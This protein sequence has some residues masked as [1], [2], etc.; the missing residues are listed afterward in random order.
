MFRDGLKRVITEDEGLELVGE[1]GDGNEAVDLICKLKPDVAVMDI[2]LPGINGIEATRRIKKCC[3]DINILC[4]TM[5]DTAEYISQILQVGA[6]GYIIKKAAA[7]E[8][9]QAI[10]VVRDGNSYL[11]PSSAKNLI[12]AYLSGVKSHEAGPNELT[13]REREILILV[14][15]GK[16]SNQ[17]ARLLQISEKTVDTHT[18]HIYEKLGIQ[19][20]IQAVKYAI[21]ANLIDPY[22][23]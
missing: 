14:A 19:N 17:I 10:R 12:G 21:R 22:D 8:L 3:P 16:T 7:D 1:S 11:Y 5:H 13:P 9:Q 15:D 4:L 18:A 23:F 6:G 20:R 2:S